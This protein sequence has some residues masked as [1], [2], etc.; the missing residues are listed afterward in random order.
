LGQIGA[1]KDTPY[2][3]TRVKFYGPPGVIDAKH[4]YMRE[5]LAEIPGTTIK[6]GGDYR[7]PLDPDTVD[8][9]EDSFAKASLGIPTL[10][11]YAAGGATGPAGLARIAPVIPA[12]GPE[13]MRADQVFTQAYKE[14]GLGPFDIGGGWS[15]YDRNL[16]FLMRMRTGNDPKENRV[17]REKWKR[18][19]EISTAN[20][21]GS[22]RTAPV[23]MDEVMAA[24]SFNNHAL[25]RFLERVKD[26]LDPNG[27]LAPG[28]SGIWPKRLRRA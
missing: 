15:W 28:K 7:F 25:L 24:Y 9:T 20:G 27:I 21:W 26:A 2:W 5:K 14:L 22:Y 11:I 23:F 12:T 6:L 4:A 19:I 1:K 16:I 8:E 13:I 17:T 18:L 10:S 3:N